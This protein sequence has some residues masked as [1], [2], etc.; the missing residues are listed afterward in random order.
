MN[1]QTSRPAPQPAA[2][3]RCVLNE[4]EAGFYCDLSLAEMRRRRAAGTG[5][6]FVKLGERRIGYRLPDLDAYLVS[7]VV[8]AAATTPRRGSVVHVVFFVSSLAS[9]S[10]SSSGR[11]STTTS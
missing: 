5:P 3:L 9:R 4:Q 7:L 1:L 6:A 10:V 11:S 8:P 2:S